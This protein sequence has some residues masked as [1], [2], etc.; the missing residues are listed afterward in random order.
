MRITRVRTFLV[1]AKMRNWLFVRIETDTPGLYGLGEATLEFQ[2]A[3]V[4]ACIE[5]LS[6]LIKGADPRNITRIWEHLY[7]Y[8]FFKGGAVTMSA[9]SGIDQA[10]HD[11]AAK[12]LGIPLWQFLG[13]LSRDRVRMYDHVG[14]GS[15]DAVYG[16]MDEGL[17][18]RIAESR[19]DGFDAIKILAVP[20][21][22][23]VDGIG[24]LESAERVM[25][26]AREA[27]GPAMD[28][29]VD[30]HGRTTA[31]MGLRL[32]KVLEPFTPLFIEEVVG[33]ELPATEMAK[34]ARAT[35]IPVAAGER[36][37][38]REQF[39]PLLQAGAIAVAQPDLCH[40][41]GITETT[42]IAALCGTF[43]VTLAPHNPLGPIAT[44]VNIH[45]GLALPN[46]LIQ[47]VMRGDV[48]WRHDVVTGSAAIVDGHVLPPTAPGIGVDIDER[49]AAE[50]PYVPSMPVGWVHE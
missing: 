4:A 21:S 16:E 9:I 40:A 23:A 14:A 50:H 2:S 7:R 10:L 17:A 27:A 45:V 47:E 44:M 28:I 34:V 38:H 46:F 25:S 12:D 35:S 32:A 19:A 20:R 33:P 30:F 41:G 31:A 39:L 22:R 42:R 37:Y 49:A 13:G 29:M 15:S 8:P 24:V 6:P 48:P 36:L 3:A 1:N 11:I 5:E 43:G 18:Q 26:I